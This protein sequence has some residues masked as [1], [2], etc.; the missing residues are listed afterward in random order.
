MY[1]YVCVYGLVVC[2]CGS[3]GTDNATNP[4]AKPQYKGCF[5]NDE[6]MITQAI[7]ITTMVRL[8]SWCVNSRGVLRL[9]N[10]GREC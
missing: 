9:G 10:V 1:V 4:K 6:V 2:V 7:P 8:E 3:P 5:T